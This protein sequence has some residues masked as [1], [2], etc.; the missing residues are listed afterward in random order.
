M[1]ESQY[2]LNHLPKSPQS[3]LPKMFQRPFVPGVPCFSNSVLDCW[4]LWGGSAWWPPPRVAWLLVAKSRRLEL[5]SGEEEP[6]NCPL[7]CHP[8]S[9]CIPPHP[10]V[11]TPH[12]PC[13]CQY[14]P[15]A[16]SCTIRG[17]LFLRLYLWLLSYCYYTTFPTSFL[18]VLNATASLAP[19][20]DLPQYHF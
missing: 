15:L 17:N 4:W 9:H 2:V 13:F 10:P 14:H 5:R 6:W 7:L 19:T 16:L 18:I 20:P 8:L 1:F 12:P 11:P 3:D